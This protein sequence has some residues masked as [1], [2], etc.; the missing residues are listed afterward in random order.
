MLGTW[1]YRLVA[2]GHASLA[3]T[4]LELNESCK[5]GDTNATCVLS[6]G[7]PTYWDTQVQLVWQGDVVL[8]SSTSI[9]S[10]AWM[11]SVSSI[12]FNVTGSV[13]LQSD[14]LLK[15][16]GSVRIRA[17]RFTAA[18]RVSVISAKGEV[19]LGSHTCSKGVYIEGLSV[20]LQG[21]SVILHCR[22]GEVKLASQNGRVFAD[23]KASREVGKT[24]KFPQFDH[25]IW[26]MAGTVILSDPLTTLFAQRV[27]IDSKKDA[28]VSATMAREL[29]NGEKS[30]AGGEDSDKGVQQVEIYTR[31]FGHLHLGWKGMS[32]FVDYIWAIGATV[33]LES[34]F[35][36]HTEGLDGCENRETKLQDLCPALLAEWPAI[37]DWPKERY[38]FESDIKF[39]VML[40]ARDALVMS[41]RS[42]VQGASVLACASGKLQVMD[43]ASL[44][45]SGRGCEAG[46]DADGAGHSGDRG[47]E[48]AMTY[49]GQAARGCWCAAR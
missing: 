47:G 38:F 31:A 19:S 11:S 4:V 29:H 22:E 9:T 37:G 3:I 7:S 16:T 6:L 21:R 30:G 41:T 20:Q 48:P 2:V 46:A 33:T 25:Q 10:Q 42:K 28:I 39:D 23:G 5:A 34:S 40:A 8:Q 32:W 27:V 45:A 14:V 13:S 44:D 26:I 36:I 43:G 35:T 17:D 1:A 12:E 18:D 15:A 24:R 49:L